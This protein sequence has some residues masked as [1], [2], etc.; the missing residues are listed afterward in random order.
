[1]QTISQRFS[2]IRRK[3]LCTLVALMCSIASAQTVAPI[4]SGDKLGYEILRHGSRGSE[5]FVASATPVSA[6]VV[7]S[8]EGRTVTFSSGR[9]DKY[10]ASHALTQRTANGKTQDWT[11]KHLLA[12]LPKDRASRAKFEVGHV[13][14]PNFCGEVDVAYVAT[15][16]D[17]TYQVAISGTEVS[18][19]AVQYLMEGRW[20]GTCGS[21]RQ[22]LRIVYSPDLDAVLESESLNFHPTS[23]LNVG[24]GVRLKAVN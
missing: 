9:V 23:F 5:I 24:N 21:G 6:D 20:R 13:L 4:K 17:V 12:W 1:M 22:V 14:P 8:P 16:S 19:K 10:D 18:L 15:P 3:Y 11:G 7:V 2:G